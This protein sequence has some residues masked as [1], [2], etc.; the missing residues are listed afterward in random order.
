MGGLA[1]SRLRRRSPCGSFCL[2][3]VRVVKAVNLRIWP[4][5]VHAFMSENGGGKSTLMKIW[6]ERTGPDSGEIIL[7]GKTVQFRTPHEARLAGIGDQE[8]TVAPAKAAR[9]RMSQRKR[10]SPIRR[11]W[12]GIFSAPTTGQSILRTI[13]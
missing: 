7:D 12:L 13:R 10:V 3:G 2:S 9:S 1:G 5:E 8:V 11:I 4:G 6:Q